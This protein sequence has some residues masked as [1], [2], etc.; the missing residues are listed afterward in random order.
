M[1]TVKRYKSEKV[2]DGDSWRHT[3]ITLKPVNPDFRTIVM[4]GTEE[5]ELQV[6]AEF[7]EVLFHD[8]LQPDNPI[9]KATDGYF[10]LGH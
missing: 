2:A 5:G 10:G 4:T 1:M 3:R 8:A 9:E 6:I 7:V